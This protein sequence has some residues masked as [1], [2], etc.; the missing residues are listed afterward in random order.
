[1]SDASLLSWGTF[2]SGLGTLILASIGVVLLVYDL[3]L[4]GLQLRETRARS[5]SAL[6]VA[7][8]TSIVYRI[9]Q[10]SEKPQPVLETR[11]MLK[12]ISSEIWAVPLVYIQARS[13]PNASKESRP[14]TFSEGDFDLLPECGKLS[15]P[16]NVARF[17][18]TIFH[19]PPGE[20]E[21]VVRWDDLPESF[22]RDFPLLVV[23]LEV[24]SAPDKVMG[25]SYSF[26]SGKKRAEWLKF[27]DSEKGARHR[28]VVVSPAS[29]N[30]WRG[31]REDAWAFLKPST[32]ELDEPNSRK[33]RRVLARM[34]K[35]GRQN[36]V[37]LGDELSQR[38]VLRRASL[39]LLQEDQDESRRSAQPRA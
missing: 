2:L 28:K 30:I 29:K 25:A 27:M 13:A 22:I 17:P 12:N 39:Q 7:L 16:L 5:N 1:M 10:N 34:S 31:P 35:T 9:G 38:Q 15:L 26:K 11:A 4:R 20:T 33:F 18:K 23:R 36:L 32:G 24:F 3:R 21:S 19:I 6:E 37:A 8:H 14:L